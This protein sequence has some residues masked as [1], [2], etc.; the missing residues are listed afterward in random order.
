VFVGAG[1]VGGFGVQIAHALGATVVAVDVDDARLGQL[2]AHGADV[3]AS[4]ADFK[5]LKKL[6]RETA[7]ARGI[8]T[9]RTRIFETSGTPAGQATAFGL[10][11]PGGY[12]SLVGYTPKAVEVRLSNLMAFDAI[13]QGNWG[14]LPEHYPAIVD[15]VLQGRVVLAPFIEHRPL[16]TINEVFAE[17]H[18]GSVLR[19]LV[20]IPES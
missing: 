14:C 7:E 2:A 4:P 18:A 1:G 8:P 12:L 5:L 19:R 17:L 15:L 20:L 10:V 3:T 11:G 16:A 9:W 13:A 6:V